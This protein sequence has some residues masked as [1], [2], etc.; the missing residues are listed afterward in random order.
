M[1]LQN[2]LLAFETIKMLWNHASNIPPCHVGDKGSS[3]Y[4]PLDLLRVSYLNLE[5]FEALTHKP[6]RLIK[7]K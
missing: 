3:I 7:L 2:I 5:R 4:S 1:V 6:E